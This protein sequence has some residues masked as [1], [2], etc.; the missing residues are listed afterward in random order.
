M[1][2]LEALLKKAAEAESKEINTDGEPDFTSLLCQ[3]TSQCYYMEQEV[4][5]FVEKYVD[6]SKIGTQKNGFVLDIM[7]ILNFCGFGGKLEFKENEIK[8]YDTQSNTGTGLDE[9]NE[10]KTYMVKCRDGSFNVKKTVLQQFGVTSTILNKDKKTNEVLLMTIGV[11]EAKF[12]LLEW[13]E[14]FNS[15]RNIEIVDP[16]S[17]FKQ[18]C[19]CSLF[20]LLI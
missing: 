17:E 12:L 5:K 2:D 1:N 10:Q 18:V 6:I 19:V 8:I 16:L 13:M 15:N 4:L 11:D 14:F 3:N 9:D 7:A 20:N